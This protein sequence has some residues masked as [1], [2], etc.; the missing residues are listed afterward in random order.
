M[1]TIIHIHS[2]WAGEK[3]YNWSITLLIYFALDYF[4]GHF[5]EDA[6]RILECSKRLREYCSKFGDVKRVVVYDKNPDGVCQ[7][8]CK[9]SLQKD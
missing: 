5:D 2:N 6:S 8:I 1:W 9:F 4:Q 7:V 3:S